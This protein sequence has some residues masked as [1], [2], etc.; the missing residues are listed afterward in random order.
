MLKIFVR[1]GI[2]TPALLRGPEFPTNLPT[3]EKGM[4]LES[5]A[6]D[7]SAILTD[8]NIAL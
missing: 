4:R 8:K 6:L 5:G 1:K 7:H 3:R 2:W